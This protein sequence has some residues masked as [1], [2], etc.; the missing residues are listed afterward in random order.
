M[1]ISCDFFWFR[2]VCR[3]LINKRQKDIVVISIPWCGFNICHNFLL[4]LTIFLFCVLIQYP[5]QQ[6]NFLF[7]GWRFQF[8]GFAFNCSCLF[9]Y[10]NK[11]LFLQA[12]EYA[13]FLFYPRSF[14]THLFVKPGIGFFYFFH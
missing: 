5:I 13:R 4:D 6:L 2:T 7:D 10:L 12:S 8:I 11:L 1:S 14:P 3:L 9:N